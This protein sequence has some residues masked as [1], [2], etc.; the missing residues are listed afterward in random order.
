LTFTGKTI[1]GGTYTGLSTISSGS[2]TSSGNITAVQNFISSSTNAVLAADGGGV[3]LRPNGAASGTGQWVVNN[4]GDVTM[5]GD[6]HLGS[7]DTTISR[8][9]AG[10]IE[11]EGKQIPSPASQASGDILYRGATNWARLA[12]GSAGEVLTMNSGATAPE[13]AAA[14]FSKSYTSANQTITNNGTLSLTHGLG[15]TPELVQCYY[16]CTTAENGY[17]VG[18]RL[19]IHGTYQTDRAREDGLLGVI[20]VPGTSTIWIRFG[21]DFRTGTKSGGSTATNDGTPANWRLVVKAWR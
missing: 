19:L 17:S 12:K 20:V 6:L 9:S 11:V 14:P 1:T 5:L 16:V 7:T 15:G 18:D 21:N 2:I 3:F 10:F 4:A 8:A 13:W